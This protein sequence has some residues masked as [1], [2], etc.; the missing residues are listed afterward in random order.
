MMVE[1]CL[2]REIDPELETECPRYLRSSKMIL[3]Q[4]DG[5]AL[6]VAEVKHRMEML[7]MRGQGVGKKPEYCPGR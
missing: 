3:L 1:T 5:E 4:V 6:E 2:W 7:L